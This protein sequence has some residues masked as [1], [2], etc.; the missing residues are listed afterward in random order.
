MFSLVLGVG[1]VAEAV[2]PQEHLIQK[3][4]NSSESCDLVVVKGEITEALPNRLFRVD[5][6]DAA[7]NVLAHISVN[8]SLEEARRLQVGDEVLIEVIPCDSC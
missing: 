1:H 5:I 6:Y 4:K 7:Y 3:T 2:N 8:V